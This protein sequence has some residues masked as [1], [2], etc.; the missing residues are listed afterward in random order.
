MV[1]S[2]TVMLVT[3][4]RAC[5]QPM[6]TVTTVPPEF[7]ATAAV[8]AAMCAAVSES[9]AKQQSHRTC[10]PAPLPEH[11]C[12]PVHELGSGLSIFSAVQYCAIRILTCADMLHAWVKVPR[13]VDAVVSQF[14]L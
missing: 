12:L 4:R 3:G 1:T 10:K 14:Y 2:R 8:C 7:T 9:N 5:S 11:R 6:P 13:M